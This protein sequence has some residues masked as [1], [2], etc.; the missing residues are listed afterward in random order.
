MDADHKHW[1]SSNGIYWLNK[2]L[3]AGKPV[4]IPGMGFM[5]E[6]MNTINSNSYNDWFKDG[7]M[8]QATQSESISK[9]L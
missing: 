9:L 5:P 6:P 7:Y 3:S 1:H 4:P 8:S 2:V